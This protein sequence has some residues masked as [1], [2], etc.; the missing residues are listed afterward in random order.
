MGVAEGACEPVVLLVEPGRGLLVCVEIGG[1]GVELDSYVP[2][3]FTNDFIVMEDIVVIG[4]W[5]RHFLGLERR[6]LENCK[7]FASALHFL[8][9]VLTYRWR[10]YRFLLPAC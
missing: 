6:G 5:G 7:G 10:R 3:D 8:P 4:H 2:V 1:T 9:L